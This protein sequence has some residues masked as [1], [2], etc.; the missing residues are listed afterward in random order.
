MEFTF[1]GGRLRHITVAATAG[2]VNN[3]NSPGT[4]KR[5]KLLY[6]RITLVADATVANR[7]IGVT[8]F[9]GAV[10]QISKASSGA[11]VA[12]TTRVL[13]LVPAGDAYA[14]DDASVVSIT[15]D[16]WILEGSD[17]IRFSILS[18]VAGDSYSGVFT[19]L[20]S[21]V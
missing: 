14:S 2:N 5:W 15:P 4:G 21:P 20:E 16:G 18:G 10:Q 13:G 12:T 6:A 1:P 19:I 9:S 8:I 11:I 3:N 7:Y 17:F